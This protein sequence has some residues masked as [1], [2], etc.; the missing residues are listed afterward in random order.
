MKESKLTYYKS[1][2]VFT[3][4]FDSD[5]EPS[6]LNKILGVNANK[7]VLKKNAVK[8]PSNP[9]GLGFYQLATNVGEDRETEF[10]V[11]T[12]LRVF[13]KKVDDINKILRENN[14]FCKLDLFLK[15]SKDAICPD[16]SLSPNAIKLLSSLNARF[17][18]NVI[19]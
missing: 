4:Y 18:V 10:A 8:N 7:I 1:Q 19:A 5:F 3:I 14:G 6:I 17:C 9:Q 12:V 13:I 11:A 2:A 16:V 15:Q